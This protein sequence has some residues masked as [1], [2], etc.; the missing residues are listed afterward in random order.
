[1]DKETKAVFAAAAQAARE[2]LPKKQAQLAALQQEIDQLM[3]VVHLGDGGTNGTKPARV[4]GKRVQ[5]GEWGRRV[6]A[7]LA[8]A[9]PAGLT[10]S[11]LH[12]KVK[13]THT[14]FKHGA[15]ELQNIL[16]RGEKLGRYMKDEMRRWKNK[17][18]APMPAIPTL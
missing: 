10:L 8:A 2:L 12:V 1:V 7:I 13:S 11:D 18:G 14:D 15:R 16:E 9:E 5:K 4:K 3:S 17:P 6:A